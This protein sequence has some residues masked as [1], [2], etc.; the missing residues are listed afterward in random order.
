MNLLLKSFILFN[1]IVICALAQSSDYLDDPALGLR[2][3]ATA[4]INEDYIDAYE[5]FEAL[6]NKYPD[7]PHNSSFRFMMA[8]SL[9]MAGKYKDA[10][11]ELESFAK[12]FPGS[13]LL[14]EACL[15][16]GHS[17]YRT[18]SYYKAASEYIAAIDFKPKA[19]TA[20]VARA[21]ITPLLQKGLTV[22]ELHKMLSDNPG[23]SMAE[24]IEFTI[25]KREIDA[26]H[27]R[28]GMRALRSFMR[29][30]PGSKDLKQARALLQEVALKS[31]TEIE[32]GLLVPAT[33][34]YREYGRS[35]I[36]AARLAL[37][38]MPENSPPVDLSIKDTEGDPIVSSRM[39]DILSEEDPVAAVGPLRSESTISAAIVLN[40][41][42]IPMITPT[43]SEAGLADIGPNIFQISS[44]IEE[45]GRA[46][47]EYA[48]KELKISEFAIIAPDDIG[49]TKIANAFA[50]EIYSLGGDVILTTYYTPGTTDF[51]QQI[52]PLREILLV[53]TESQLRA[54]LLDTSQ[55]WDNKKD[56]LLASEDWPVKLGGLFLPGY[57]DD[58]KLLIP[59]VKYHVIRT[60][61]LGGDGWDSEE[62]LRE[63]RQY[64]DN[65]V[66]ATDF[67]VRS[68]DN[69]WD[70]FSKAYDAAYYH[71]PDKVAALTYDAVRMV[72]Q[73]ISSGIRNP[74]DM[75]L[76][77]SQLQ[78]FR[79]VSGQ[80]SFKGF[81][82][83]N[84]SIA[85]YSI[86]G[87][88]LA[89]AK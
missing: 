67:H 53:K 66:F 76:Y 18:G 85:V 45:I 13:Q 33:G 15:L 74:D 48:V 47:A 9:Y 29:R 34:N 24:Q 37:K 87:K 27:Y 56:T 61:F 16:L 42:G 63:V 77:L 12:T 11:V 59:Q 25:A 5:K 2:A 86:N 41:R 78:G 84:N 22:L 50:K 72:L 60:R 69:E 71:I 6:S 35:M 89:G 28:K 70:D 64:V 30:F 65:A 14:G 88:K 58:L 46:M 55:F 68:D 26:G 54:G 52:S 3:A 20:R 31:D 10:A 62:L 36:E 4:F 75:R 8:R 57:A 43:A 49:G 38:Q 80:I 83:A 79:G 17:L 40:E 19:K 7:D 82:R 32:I 21:N 44:P 39:A 81:G 1:I 51:K 23:T 73:G